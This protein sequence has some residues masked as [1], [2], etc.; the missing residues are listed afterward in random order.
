VQKDKTRLQ[1]IAVV[2]T[3]PP[4]YSVIA[5]HAMEQIKRQ[6]IKPI[7][8]HFLFLIKA[9]LQAKSADPHVKYDITSGNA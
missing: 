4:T 1:P 7:P 3:S 5:R 8:T 6:E 9:N 2:P